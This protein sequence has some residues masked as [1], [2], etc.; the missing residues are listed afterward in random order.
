MH[1][2]DTYIQFLRSVVPEICDVPIYLLKVDESA[3]EWNNAW[4][5]AFSPLADLQAQTTLESLGLWRGRGVCIRVRDD[6]EAWSP[7]CKAGTLLH[8]MSHALEWLSQDGALATAAELSPVARELLQGNES[9]ILQDAGICRND[10]IRGQHGADFVRLSMH[11]YWRARQQVVLSPADLQ[12]LH[13]V[14][15]LGPERYADVT[16]ALSAELAMSRNLNLRRLREPP[17]AFLRL[18]R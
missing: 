18:F 6:F 13:G 16:E 12:F 5:A 4:M 14:Y 1:W 10:L 7:R 15:S 2:S 3:V 11:L 9:E 8:E 17:E